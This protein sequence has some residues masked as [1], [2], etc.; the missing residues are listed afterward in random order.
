MYLQIIKDYFLKIFVLAVSYAVIGYFSLWLAIP[1]GFASPVWPPAGVALGL[2][3]LWG[4]RFWPGILLGSMTVNIW[5]SQEAYTNIIA[6]ANGMGIALGAS[7][8]AVVSKWCIEKVTQPP[9]ELEDVKQITAIVMVGGPICCIVS[10]TIGNTILLLNGVIQPDAWLP[11]WLTW[12]IGDCIGVVACAPVLLA[13]FAGSISQSRKGIVVMPLMALLVTVI[14]LFF[15]AQRW[16]QEQQ[17]NQAIKEMERAVEHMQDYLDGYLLSLFSLE[18]LFQSSNYVSREEFQRFATGFVSKYPGIQAL[19]WVPIVPSSE[20]ER[21]IHMAKVEGLDNFE[22]TEYN[23]HFNKIERAKQREIYYPVFYIEPLKTNETALGYDLGSNHRC[24]KAIEKTLQTL[25]PVATEKI[26]LIQTLQPEPVFLVFQ[27]VIKDINFVPGFV[28][29]VFKILPLMEQLHQHLSNL[30]TTVLIYDEN[31]EVIYN[32][33]KTINQQDN[34]KSLDNF[35]NLSKTLSVANREW[36]LNFQFKPQI[37]FEHRFWSIWLLVV[38]GFFIIGMLSYVLL[39]ITGQAEATKRQIVRRTME[40][41]ASKHALSEQTEVLEKSNKALEEFA[42]I[43]SHNLK[44]PLRGVSNY[45]QFISEDYKDKLDQ[46]G[47][48][49]LNNMR[50]LTRRME[51]FINDLLKYSRVEYIDDVRIETDIMGLLVEV[52][53]NLSHLIKP[54]NVNVVTKEPLPTIYCNK[55]K[56]ME[57]FANLITN[58]IKYNKRKKIEIIIGCDINSVPSVFYVQDNG[59]GIPDHLQSKVFKIFQRLH[60]EDEYGGGTGAGLSI[61][62]KII[63]AYR[64]SI[65]IKS[66]PGE[67]S[68]FYFTLPLAMQKN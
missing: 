5:A 42:Y 12:W 4:Y 34:Y 33:G 11:A 57:L 41:E 13:L 44:E 22:I 18:K 65:W 19:E 67:G 37:S 32:P 31:N 40:L 56:M 25:Q 60:T 9:W 48:D 63:E 14:Y 23:L 52:K 15:S 61:V 45:C 1:P 26:M 62:K 53:E 16:E 55:T 50:K 39:I 47:S 27:P 6:L 2:V 46:Q 43:A 58:A 66:K 24:L 3:L 59:I 17:N 49:M 29:G 28:L 30:E 36:K 38:G 51:S 35:I 10:A 21:L 64:G 8:Q 20:R 68:T 7:L 54:P